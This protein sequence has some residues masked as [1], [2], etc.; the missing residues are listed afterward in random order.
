MEYIWSGIWAGGKIFRKNKII[1]RTVLWQIEMCKK[2]IK[3]TTILYIRNNV[4]KKNT[5]GMF[6][7]IYVRRI[8]WQH[9][10]KL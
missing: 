6:R 4:C 2:E 1:R 8:L 3:K 7:N 9:I 10:L 5:N